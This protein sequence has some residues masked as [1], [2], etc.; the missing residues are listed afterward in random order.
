M[1]RIAPVTFLC[2]VSL[3]VL[4]CGSPSGGNATAN[5]NANNVMNRSSGPPDRDMLISAENRAFEAWKNRDGGF[6][7]D[8]LTTGFVTFGRE[9][10]QD[11]AAAVKEITDA[12]CEVN[13]YA[14]SDEAVTLMGAD[15]AILTFK[16]AADGTCDGQ[17]IPSQSWGATIYVRDGE[18]WKA[19]YHNEIPIADTATGPAPA[20]PAPAAPEAEAEETPVDPFTQAL[21]AAEKKAWEGRKTRDVKAISEVTMFDLIYLDADGS[22]RYT[23]EEAARMWFGPGCTIKSFSLAEPLGRPITANA[24]VLTYK[25]AIDGKCGTGSAKNIWGTTVYMK[26]G[27]AWKALMIFNRPA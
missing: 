11:K 6:F 8:F 27:G 24:A 5:S 19:A 1:Q 25:A 15:G 10:R 4:S 16:S 26:E 12:N 18:K 9:G 2:L 3:L 21:M 17:K 7:E 13:S 20:K 14:L 23:R 22:G